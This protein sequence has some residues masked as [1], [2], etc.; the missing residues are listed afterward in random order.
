VKR[1]TKLV[2]AAILGTTFLG[3]IGFQFWFDY[4]LGRKYDLA[5]S[6]MESRLD[7]FQAR[8][9]NFQA[10]V[11]SAMGDNEELQRRVN[12]GFV[13]LQDMYFSLLKKNDGLAELWKSTKPGKAAYLTFDDGPTN[14]TPLLLD[15]L[16]TAKVRATFFVNGRPEYADTYKRIAEEGHLIGNHTYSHDYATIYQSTNSYL[17]DSDKLDAFLS[18]LGLKPA[19]MYRFP[20]GASNEIATRLGGPDLTGRISVAMADRGYRF[21]E[22]NVVV[23]GGES[24]AD[25]LMYTTDEIRRSAVNQAIGKRIA[26]IL[27]HDGPGHRA[28][29]DAV[30]GIISDLKKAGFTFDVLP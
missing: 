1:S 21:Y 25:G 29:V 18:S 17:K 8:L 27:L 14:N 22:W 5:R 16:K 24:K 30:P 3:A 11:A 9:S 7:A 13:T 10:A 23:G 4:S 20:G 19:H 26:V 6:D 15:E 12:D 28:S 2:I